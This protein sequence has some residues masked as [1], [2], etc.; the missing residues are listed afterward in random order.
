MIFWKLLA[1]IALGWTL[2]FRRGKGILI[3]K[4]SEDGDVA[5]ETA[6]ADAGPTW[7][8][9]STRRGFPGQRTT[10]GSGSPSAEPTEEESPSSRPDGD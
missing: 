1:W 4:T 8:R 3:R 10:P 6:R 2:V 7:R 5:A 9:V